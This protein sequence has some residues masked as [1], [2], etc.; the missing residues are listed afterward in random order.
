MLS[1]TIR[2]VITTDFFT[3]CLRSVPL[4]RGWWLACAL[5]LAGLPQWGWAQSS[6]NPLE[7]SQLR[8][9][10]TEDGLFL[11]AQIRMELPSIVEDALNKGIAMF[12][13]A[14][15][16]LLRDRW[17][18]YDRKVVVAEKHIRLAYQPLT[19]RWRL[20]MS[21]APIGNAGLGVSFS[22]NFDSLQDALQAVQRISNWKIADVNALEA[23]ARHNIE[24]RFRLDMSQ[25]PRPFQLGAVGRSDWNLAASRNFRLSPGPEAGK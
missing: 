14:E 5:I 11:T 17:Y 6:A 8:V 19:R 20:N 15:A 7:I 18:W 13:V 12:F 3:H 2:R 24:F 22:Q 16:E 21:P 9:D 23:D 4:R 1:R 25:L 10:R